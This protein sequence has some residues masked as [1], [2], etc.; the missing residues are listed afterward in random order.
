[1]TAQKTISSTSGGAKNKKNF[2]SASTSS[3]TAVAFNPGPSSTSSSDTSSYGGMNAAAMA[4]AMAAASNGS[5]GDVGSL[6]GGKGGSGGH[7]SE[8]GK[9]TKSACSASGKKKRHV[10]GIS[11]SSGSVK[12]NSSNPSMASSGGSGEGGSG[13][14]SFPP[15]HLPPEVAQH[16]LNLTQQKQRSMDGA[17]KGNNNVCN[18]GKKVFGPTPP[19]EGGNTSANSSEVTEATIGNIDLHALAQ[20]GVFSALDLSSSSGNSVGASTRD[21]RSMLDAVAAMAAAAESSSSGDGQSGGAN[22]SIHADGATASGKCGEAEMRALMGMFVEIMGMSLDSTSSTSSSLP[23]SMHGNGGKGTENNGSSKGSSGST[24]SSGGNRSGPVSRLRMNVPAPPPNHGSPNNSSSSIHSSHNTG[25][26]KGNNNPSSNNPFPVFSMMF[27]GPKNN[28]DGQNSSIDPNV[29]AIPPPPGGWPPGAAAAAA[30]AVA[31]AAAGISPNNSSTAF[32]DGPLSSDFSNCEWYPEYFGDGNVSD[33]HHH[34]HHHHHHHHYNHKKKS[35]DDSHEDFGREIKGSTKRNAR[36]SAPQDRPSCDHSNSTST[37]NIETEEFLD[38]AMQRYLA[39]HPSDAAAQELLREEEASS[40]S[41]GKNNDNDA[42][43]PDGEEKARRAAKKREKKNRKREKARRETAVKSVRASQKRREKN[44]LS[45]RGR[46]VAACNSEEISRLDSLLGESPFRSNVTVQDDLDPE[47]LEELGDTY[48][49]PEKE[50]S[51][52]MEWLLPSCI[53]KEKRNICDLNQVNNANTHRYDWND[54]GH[55]ET[56]RY[57]L[58]AYVMRLCFSV[59]FTPGKNGRSAVHVASFAGD[60]NFVRLVV[61]QKRQIEKDCNDNDYHN[62]FKAGN[63]SR[64]MNNVAANCLDAQCRDAGWTPLHFAVAGGWIDVAEV[65]MAGGCNIQTKSNP[66]LTSYISNGKGL[67][68]RELAE[69]I[70]SENYANTIRCKG[71]ALNETIQNVNDHKKDENCAVIDTSQ[72][73]ILLQ[74]LTDIEQNGYNALPSVQSIINDSSKTSNESSSSNKKSSLIETDGK[75]SSTSKKKKKKKKKGQHSQQ[76]Q[77]SDTLSKV[78]PA[79]SDAGT[80]LASESDPLITALLGMGFSEDQVN[81]AVKACGGTSRATA[82]ELVMWILSGGESNSDNTTESNNVARNGS[83]QAHHE[84]T[85]MQNNVSSPLDGH[86][87]KLVNQEDDKRSSEIA[88]REAEAKAVAERLALKREE[89]KRIRREWNERE[90]IRQRKESQAKLEEEVERVRRADIEKSKAEAQ[91]VAKMRAVLAASHHHHQQQQHYQNPM[92]F[93][94]TQQNIEKVSPHQDNPNLIEGT[95]SQEFSTTIEN[96]GATPLFPGNTFTNAGSGV[97]NHHQ[98]VA[99]SSIDHHGYRYD[100]TQEASYTGHMGSSL[101]GSRAV[102]SYASKQMFMNQTGSIDPYA[103]PGYSQNFAPPDSTMVKNVNS[104]ISKGSS[105]KQ[106]LAST[107]LDVNGFEFP[108]LGKEKEEPAQNTTSKVHSKSNPQNVDGNISPKVK[109][110]KQKTGNKHRNNNHNSPT[111]VVIERSSVPNPG[112]SDE[113]NHQGLPSATHN[114]TIQDK[115]SQYSS[116]NTYNTNPLGEIRATAKEFVPF[117]FTPA[118]SA[119]NEPTG[120]HLH[121]QTSANERNDSGNNLPL[122][123]KSVQTTQ[124]EKG[125]DEILNSVNSLLATSSTNPVPTQHQQHSS[126]LASASSILNPS[127]ALLLDRP[128]S[129]SPAIYNNLNNPDTAVSAGENH[130]RGLHSGHSPVPSSASSITGISSS[131]AEDPLTASNPVGNMNSFESNQNESVVATAHIPSFFESVLVTGSNT[132]NVV[133]VGGA[134]S[135]AS[136]S[137]FRSASSN[138]TGGGSSIWGLGGA[139]STHS[140]GFAAPIPNFN[141]GESDISI[142]GLPVHGSVSGGVTSGGLFQSHTTKGEDNA[143][144]DIDNISSNDGTWGSSGTLGGGKSIW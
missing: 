17:N 135:S 96:A 28:Q 44:I 112:F 89:Q 142:G 109:K 134:S 102:D 35:N 128:L 34:S 120:E 66:A 13:I 25:K 80:S 9:A 12:S 85:N 43:G 93:Q 59:V 32:P 30:A 88:S 10:R 63:E 78:S 67:T 87:L 90:Q 94:Q 74:R 104:R 129:A 42:N 56:A 126:L 19:P 136:Q 72:R 132:D 37:S 127:S 60:V 29:N 14:G 50:L 5:F 117:N 49:S 11:V 139:T 7:V 26:S 75:E 47:I 140:G 3:S 69:V 122:P 115:H 4:A 51:Q 123:P 111:K 99:S 24:S 52:N 16:Y 64:D 38:G 110:V 70:K 106:Q 137:H 113:I 121:A 1:M 92:I 55:Q 124:E 116:D 21:A 18:N 31:A 76:Q 101:Q 125:T 79:V 103:P 118:E 15:F 138:I 53:A 62:K 45:W 97:E 81:E 22:I 91:R 41:M 119:D 54:N 86:K 144:K 82:D 133:G 8:S 23:S 77:Q 108:E 143:K 95:K 68:P 58:S 2:S 40:N 83:N 33:S 65:L 61:E 141:M 39:E 100:H 84:V 27:G 130:L 73:D 71:E 46:V 114:T 6:V 98:Y 57:R 105:K 107:S 48:L 20:S 36:I 131:A